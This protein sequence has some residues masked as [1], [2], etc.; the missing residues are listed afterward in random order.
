[1]KLENILNSD[2]VTDDDPI[3]LT[4]FDDGLPLRENWK[5]NWF[6]D[7]ILEHSAL[8][9][10]QVIYTQRRGWYIYLRR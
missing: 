3:Q 2:L 4:I 8:E 5:G 10:T 6:N 7:Q 1:M 9:V